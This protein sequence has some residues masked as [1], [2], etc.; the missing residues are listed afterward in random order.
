MDSSL[1]SVKSFCSYVV[2]NWCQTNPT[3]PKSDDISRLFSPAASSLGAKFGSLHP[4]PCRSVRLQS[5]HNSRFVKLFSFVS[6][7]LV[8]S[9]SLQKL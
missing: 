1:L 5:L 8:P 7:P 3:M 4:A 2:S 6:C 9:F